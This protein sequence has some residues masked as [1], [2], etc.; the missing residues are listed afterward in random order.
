MQLLFYKIANLEALL[1]QE[2]LGTHLRQEE[3]MQ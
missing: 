3:L 2:N 1:E